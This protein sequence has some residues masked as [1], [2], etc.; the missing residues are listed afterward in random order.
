MSRLG[1][2][3]VRSKNLRIH[4]P[5]PTATYPGIAELKGF[6]VHTSLNGAGLTFTLESTISLG[7]IAAED[8]G[9]R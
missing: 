7:S 4:G 8:I 6:F 9:Q 2:R 5:F 1:G 3:S